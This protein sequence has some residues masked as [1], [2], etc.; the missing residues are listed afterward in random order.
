MDETTTTSGDEGE[1]SAIES[2]QENAPE[3]IEPP[4]PGAFT[5]PGMELQ[6]QVARAAFFGTPKSGFSGLI[7]VGTIA[8]FAMAELTRDYGT[9]ES[10]LILVGVIAFHE[11]GHY[12][13]MRLF[14][15]R[16]V[17]MFFIPFLGAAVSGKK[18]NAAAWKDAVVS[19]AGPMPGLV[20]G[21]ALFVSLLAVSA[22][23]EIVKDIALTAVFLNAFNLLPFSNLDGGRFFLRVLFVRHRY[24]ELAFAVLTGLALL[25]LAYAIDEWTLAIFAFL[26]LSTLPRRARVLSGAAALRKA[27]PMIGTDPD[28]LDEDSLRALYRAARGLV[29]G[30]NAH[31]ERLTAPLMDEIL[32]VGQ[33][34]PSFLASL[35]L[36]TTWMGGIACAFVA[37]VLYAV[38]STPPT[39]ERLPYPEIGI[40]A[41]FPTSP[42]AYVDDVTTPMGTV[43]QLTLRE[44]NGFVQRYTIVIQTAE[45]TPT[46]D[47]AVRWMDAD[48]DAFLARIDVDARSTEQAIALS[49]REGR[50]IVVDAGYRV[51]R[52]RQ[53]LDG[54]RLVV[55]SVSAPRRIGHADSFFNAF[56]FVDVE[57]PPPPPDTDDEEPG[58]IE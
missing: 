30:A 4:V 26:S 41:A 53:Y 49:G 16:D 18:R 47:E 33:P 44:T 17:K 11:F 19:L 43:P 5:E 56:D 3:E 46:V 13:F 52:L 24:A 45:R 31:D 51:W 48:R 50:E 32:E 20:I 2:V 23:R 38:A 58:P 27:Q 7:L 6:Y 10:I 22:P 9:F 28:A 29:D 54:D 55:V 34:A 25:A 39:F 12:V 37:I 40:A 14:G 36:L 21:L 42:D 35:A 57:G 8:F 15:Y 1:A